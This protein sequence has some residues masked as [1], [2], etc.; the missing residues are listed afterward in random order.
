MS[1]AIAVFGSSRRNGNTGR[2][3][4]A[5]AS[6]LSIDVVDL[7]EKRISPYDYQHRNRGDAFEPLM[8]RILQHDQVIFASPVYWYAVS[9]HMKVFLDRI[10]DLLD[11]PELSE[12]RRQL[13]AMCAYVLCTSIYEEVPAPFIDA[14]KMTFDYLGMT[15]GGCLHANCQDGFTA[16]SCEQDIKDFV[17]RV[18]SFGD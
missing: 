13:K 1:T 12:N 6:R 2:L 17:A 16:L 5:V 10:S 8:E 11:I 15:Y 7:A 3:M 14:F 9:A 18:R 4:D